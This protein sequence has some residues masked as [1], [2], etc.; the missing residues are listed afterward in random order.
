M[1][2]DTDSNFLG[3]TAEDVEDLIKPK[4]KNS[5]NKKSITCSSLDSRPKEDI[6]LDSLKSTLKEKKGLVSVAS[7][8]ARKIS[9]QVQ[10]QVK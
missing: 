8:I 4:L 6:L 7:C 3:I 9:Q 2:M 5:L 1:E 10:L